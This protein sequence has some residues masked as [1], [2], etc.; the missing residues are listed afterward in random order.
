MFEDLSDKEVLYRLRDS[1][2][3]IK[4]LKKDLVNLRE[5]KRKAKNNRIGETVGHQRGG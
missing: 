1:E 4:Q 3:Q 5:E 2:A